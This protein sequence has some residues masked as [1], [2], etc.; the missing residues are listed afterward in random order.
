LDVSQPVINSLCANTLC[1]TGAPV[2]N[3]TVDHKL[4]ILSSNRTTKFAD[5]VAYKVEKANLG[6]GANRY[7]RK[8]PEISADY[9]LIP[10]PDDYK[11]ANEEYGYDRGHQAPLA[12]FSNNDNY[13][14]VN[15][16]SNI[17]PQKADLNQ[18]SWVRLEN[19]ERRLITAHN[20]KN[21]YVVTGHIMT[22][23]CLCQNYLMHV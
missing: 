9:T 1:P 2:D 23:T 5:W 11:G 6:G 18:G 7:W 17:T 20:Y 3:F 15:Y 19:A 4:I 12:N 22:Q 16:L 13:A 14:V 8:D 10:S 21:L